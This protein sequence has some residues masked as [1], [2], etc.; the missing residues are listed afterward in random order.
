MRISVNEPIQN[1][2]NILEDIEDATLAFF[3]NKAGA[4][5]SSFIR[6]EIMNHEKEILSK[7]RYGVC[8]QEG[9]MAV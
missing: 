1:V 5:V 6:A 3:D 8:I 4:P 2:D 7:S 9:L